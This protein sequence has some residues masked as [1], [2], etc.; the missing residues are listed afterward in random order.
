[1]TSV[2]AAPAA[3]VAVASADV[4]PVDVVVAICKEVYFTLKS[5]PTDL[6][7]NSST[8]TNESMTT[9]DRI[10]LGFFLG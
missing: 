5:R 7:L 6:S 10:D 3:V 1:M 8:D 2:V 4:V 9:N